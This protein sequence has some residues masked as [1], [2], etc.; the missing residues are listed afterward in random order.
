M[1]V[2]FIRGTQEALEK[3]M[4]QNPGSIQEVKCYLR[5]EDGAIIFTYPANSS[6][7]G[8]SIDFD[9]DF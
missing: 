7:P 5:K 9:I 3:L 6:S 2:K 4:E 8:N 1:Q